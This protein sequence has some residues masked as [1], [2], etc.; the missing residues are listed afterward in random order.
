L[1][2]CADKAH[3]VITVDRQFVPEQPEELRR[4]KADPPPPAKGDPY[5]AADA[6][7]ILIDASKDCRRTLSELNDWLDQ[8]RGRNDGR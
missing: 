8:A 1:T 2:A 4:C 5:A 6:I 3:E 7:S